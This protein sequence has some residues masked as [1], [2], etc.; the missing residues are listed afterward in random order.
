LT[1]F[2]PTRTAAVAAMIDG[3]DDTAPAAVDLFWIPL[4]AGG[5]VVRHV[6]A[7]YEAASA[8]LSRRPRTQLFHTALVVRIAETSW[9]IESAPIRDDR[10]PD[11]GVVAE[12]PV[13][14]R[15]AGRFRLFRYEIR[16]WRGGVLAD[17]DE[18]VGGPV[19]VAADIGRAERVLDLVP[20]VPTPVWGRDGLHTG[21]MWNS[22]SLTA[23]LLVRAG[24]DT[25]PLEPPTGGRA[26][27][28]H[29]G[30]AIAGRSG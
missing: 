10:G 2:R 19:R 29:A 25:S 17:A 23:W 6:G 28:W 22:N 7:I 8:L 9:V 16:R 21:D 30:I 15:L 12:G 5:R 13:G 1:D 14:M 18:A 20:S 26:P 27:G 24:V 11:R 4:G 3:V